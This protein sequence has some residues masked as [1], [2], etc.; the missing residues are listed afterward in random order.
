MFCREHVL[1]VGSTHVMPG[2][3][4]PHKARKG[5]QLI[6]GVCDPI[7]DGKK[8]TYNDK[9]MTTCQAHAWHGIASTAS[10]NLLSDFAA[11]RLI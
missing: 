1:A 5:F 4:L 7:A 10:A 6:L 2:L 11:K 8:D 3:S 9:S